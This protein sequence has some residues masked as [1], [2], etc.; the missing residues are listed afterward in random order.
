MNNLKIGFDLLFFAVVGL[1]VLGS[2]FLGEE[3]SQRLAI[4]VLV[5]SFAVTQLSEPLEKLLGGK[6]E[7]ITPA[8]ISIIIMSICVGLCMLGKNVRDKKWP[9]SKIKAL[10]SGALSGV[11]AVAYI[12]ASI[13]E[14]TRYNLVTD[15]NLAARAYDLRI[16]LA[17]ALI[18]WLLITYMS[19]GK[20]KK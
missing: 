8:I 20:A 2:F 15:H 10:I 12:I 18:V 6:S 9:K 11:V 4:G 7:L 19:V 17:S 5:G 16:Y 14:Q 3:K 13:P 1:A